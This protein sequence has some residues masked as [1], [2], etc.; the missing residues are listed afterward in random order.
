MTPT[1]T[2]G[3]TCTTAK[4]SSHWSC[5]LV[6]PGGGGGGCTLNTRHTNRNY[7]SDRDRSAVI[8]HL[9]GNPLSITHTH[10]HTHAHTHT[11]IALS[12]DRHSR[13]QRAL[14]FIA[15]Q[16]SVLIHSFPPAPVP[17]IR[18]L[19]QLIWFSH[20]YDHA[21]NISH[22]KMDGKFSDLALTRPNHFGWENG[23]NVFR[24]RISREH[25]L[26]SDLFTD[27]L[28]P[29]RFAE[30]VASPLGVLNLEP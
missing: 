6:T 4:P 21:R 5:R 12:P 20:R 26:F 18:S 15:P 7:T 8:E 16:F 30:A 22:R 19:F 2:F 9:I 10:T 28:F 1:E 3:I 14:S 23:R 17:H 24:S 27:I 29:P 25:A 13:M 11:Q